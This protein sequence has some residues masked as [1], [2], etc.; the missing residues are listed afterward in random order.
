MGLILK[1]LICL[2][3]NS[4]SVAD[5]MM[6]STLRVIDDF[7]KNLRNAIMQFVLDLF[8]EA[9]ALHECTS[10]FMRSLFEFHLGDLFEVCVF[11]RPQAIIFFWWLRLR[12]VAEWMRDF[13]NF[14]EFRISSNPSGNGGVGGHQAEARVATEPIILRMAKQQA[15][16]LHR[17]DFE[18]GRFIGIAGA[19]AYRH[20]VSRSKALLH[21]TFDRTTRDSALF[22]HFLF[23]F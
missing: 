22:D 3:N 7:K 9:V 16:T 1:N 14:Y 13:Y 8:P 19:A 23:P 12:V 4:N 6:T 20:V 21:S 10:R 17:L 2:S 18:A 5:Y 15:K 11:T